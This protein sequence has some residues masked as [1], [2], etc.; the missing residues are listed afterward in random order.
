LNFV[1]QAADKVKM[2]VMTCKHALAEGLPIIFATWINNN[3]NFDH[4]KKSETPHTQEK[5]KSNR[6][7][8][9]KYH[10]IWSNIEYIG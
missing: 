2:D 9:I 4:Q 10:Q 6:I 3:F 8:S 7:S 5:I 1:I